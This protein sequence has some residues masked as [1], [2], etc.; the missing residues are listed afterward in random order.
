LHAWLSINSHDPK[1]RDPVTKEVDYDLLDADVEK[2][3]AA[4]AESNP[5]L[6]KAVNEIISSVN[7]ALAKLEP[8]LEEALRLKSD[9]YDLPRWT[10][11]DARKQAKIEELQRLVK[12]FRAR[13]GV[14]GEVAPQQFVTVAKQNGID[15]SVATIAHYLRSGGAGDAN[16]A[17]P[18]RIKFLLANKDFLPQFFPDLYDSQAFLATLS[19]EIKEAVIASIGR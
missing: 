14:T 4:L 5:R 16:R 7:P 8:E 2:A 15:D 12:Q 11:I 18:A 1:Y 19:P 3:K 10:G 6:V 13:L 9:M 17:N